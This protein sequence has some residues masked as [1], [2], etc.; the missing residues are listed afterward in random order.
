MTNAPETRMAEKETPLETM[1]IEAAQAGILESMFYKFVGSRPER[2]EQL[3]AAFRKRFKHEMLPHAPMDSDPAWY[4]EGPPGHGKTTAHMEAAREF[5]ELMGMEFREEISQMDLVYGLIDENTVVGEIIEL[6]GE[7]SNKEVAGLMTK[8]RIG[9]KEFMGHLPDWRLAAVMQAGYGYVLFDD[10]VNAT[11]QVQGSM[12][13][14]LQN[15]SAGELNFSLA[16]LAQGKWTA[17]FTEDGKLEGKVDMRTLRKEQLSKIRKR[18]SSVHFGLC[19]NRGARDGNKTFP[20]TSAVATRVKRADVTDT[21]DAWIKRAFKNKND[22]IADAGY[23]TFLKMNAADCF[24][25]L[26]KPETGIL[27]QM[28]TP[29]S[30]DNNMTDIRRIVHKHGGI[31]AISAMDDKGKADVLYEIQKASG[32]NIGKEAGM[33]VAMFYTQLFLGAAPI[34]EDIIKKGEVDVELIRQKYNG[35]NT[36][37]GNNFGWSLASSLAS[38]AAYEISKLIGTNPDAKRKKELADVNSPLALEVRK[39]LKHFSYGI[40]Q[41]T[42]KMLATFTADQMLRRLQATNPELFMENGAYRVPSL[43]T[44]QLLAFGIFRDNQQYRVPENQNALLDSLSQMGNF[45]GVAGDNLINE[46]RNYLKP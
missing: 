32:R 22:E 34:A 29:R 42:D 1:S 14:L 36:P 26:A 40:N 3:K 24:S 39:V 18:S 25:Q 16:E 28:P 4:L 33:K 45:H 12:L 41:F 7:T 20:I 15:G 31:G 17:D 5:A 6:G 37:D 9:N 13:G 43:E 11:H 35:G 10:F 30:N 8:I 23:T 46:T 44:C 2:D 38:N 19:G 27:P 21:V